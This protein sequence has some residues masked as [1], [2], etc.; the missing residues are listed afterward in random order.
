MALKPD[1]KFVD[2]TDVSYF[3]P[4]TAQRGIAVIFG[5]T[6]GSG[7]AMDDPSAVVQ[8]PTGTVYGLLAGGIGSG[9]PIVGIL[10]TDVVNVDLT[11]YHLNQHQDQVQ[12]GGKVTLLRRGTCVT[13]MIATGFNPT[14]GQIA[15]A[16]DTVGNMTGVTAATFATLAGYGSWSKIGTWLSSKDTDGYA[17]LEVNLV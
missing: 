8:A 2:G 6:A 10:L 9:C 17:K 11:K 15:L 13:N 12:I 1:R 7:V 4:T 14:A 5:S 3:M 16:Y